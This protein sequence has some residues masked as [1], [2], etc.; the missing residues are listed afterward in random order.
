MSNGANNGTAWATSVGGNVS[1]S[2]GYCYEPYGGAPSVNPGFIRFSTANYG[3]GVNNVTERMRIMPGGN[4]GIG[5][6]SPG[7]TL[8]VNGNGR[9]TSTGNQF[10]SAPTNGQPVTAS[11]R[12]TAGNWIVGRFDSLATGDSTPNCV[13]MG[14][15]NG[16][17]S[18]TGQATIGSHNYNLTQWTT[19]YITNSN[20]ITYSD[21]NL[22]DNIITADNELCYNNIKKVRLVRYNYREDRSAVNLGKDDK[23]RLGVIAQEFQEIFPK[24][25]STIDDPTTKETFLSVNTDQMYFC[26]V[27]CV[28]QQQQLIE[29]QQEQINK[30]K[31]Q[32]ESYEERFNDLFNRLQSK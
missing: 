8:D 26:L 3:Y 18:L 15:L 5:T 11:F 12:M 23:N 17:G 6:I 27:G 1:I 20:N 4:V 7:A 16:S 13:V 25:V 22:K 21:R 32:I 24:S 30:L 29:D 14:S 2:A 9:F 31:I 10:G 28:K 19:L